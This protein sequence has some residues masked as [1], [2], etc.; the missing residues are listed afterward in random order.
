M[1]N[2]HRKDYIRGQDFKGAC[3]EP[4][5]IG[6]HLAKK[7]YTSIDMFDTFDWYF[8]FHV[9]GAF[10]FRRSKPSG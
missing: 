6:F 4:N 5:N 1:D 3:P 8:N 10:E 7:H 9:T 2:R